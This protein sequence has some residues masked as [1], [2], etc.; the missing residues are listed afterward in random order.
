MS[1]IRF[2][3]KKK[4][5]VYYYMHYAGN[6]WKLLHRGGFFNPFWMIGITCSG[7]GIILGHVCFSSATHAWWWHRKW[8]GYVCFC[9]PQKPVTFFISNSYVNTFFC[10]QST[11]Y[12]F[13]VMLLLGILLAAVF[14][15]GR[16]WPSLIIFNC[17]IFRESSKKNACLWARIVTQPF[18]Y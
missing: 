13:F 17:K 14:L 18:S 16:H 9:G 2:S 4:T 5:R 15:K 7:Y 1:K 8:T 6:L 10:A 11:F 3:Y 12:C